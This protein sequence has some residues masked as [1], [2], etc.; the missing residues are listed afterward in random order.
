MEHGYT[1]SIFAVDKI[2]VYK[3]FMQDS[4]CSGGEMVVCIFNWVRM[5]V[6]VCVHVVVC[7]RFAYMWIVDVSLQFPYL[8][9]MFHAQ[10]ILLLNFQPFWHLIWSLSPYLSAFIHIS[11]ALGCP[12]ASNEYRFICVCMRAMQRIVCA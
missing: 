9:L 4:S 1:H 6:C 2:H 12:N 11:K 8:P 3:S 10:T 5:C 7:V